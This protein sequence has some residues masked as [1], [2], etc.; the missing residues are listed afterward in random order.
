MFPAHLS[1]S[2]GVLAATDTMS[3]RKAHASACAKSTA[4]ERAVSTSPI[5]SPLSGQSSA[6]LTFAGVFTYVGMTSLSP[7]RPAHA[8]LSSSTV[9]AR[10][11][12]MTACALV[13]A[14]RCSPP[15]FANRSRARSDSTARSFPWNHRCAG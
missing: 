15:A 2:C 13:A 14:V 3:P 12:M 11:S 7:F 10:R 6:G 5:S 4:S 8:L 9:L 1:F